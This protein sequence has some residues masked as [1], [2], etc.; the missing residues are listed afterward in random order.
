MIKTLAKS[1]RENKLASILSPI[2]MMGEVA[3]EV[4][5]P[6]L[7][8]L[9]IDNG[10]SEENLPYVWKIGFWMLVSLLLS[11]GCGVLSAAMAAKASVGLATNLRTDM[12]YHIQGFSFEN[13]DKFS[14]A[15]LITRL[16]TDVTNIQN[17]YQMIIRMLVRAPLMV[18]FSL[19]MAFTIDF[20]LP[21]VFVVTVPVLSFALYYLITHAHGFFMRMFKIYDRMNQVVQENLIGIRTVKAY[22]REKEEIKKFEEQS[23]EIRNITIA[24]EKLMILNAPIMFG[25]VYFCT[26]TLCYFGANMIVRGQLGTGELMSLIT[27]TMQILLSLMMV[28]MVL[29]TCVMARASGERIVEVLNEE[30]TLTN[31][32]DPDYEVKDGSIVFE[33]VSFAYDGRL[34]NT[35]LEHVSLSIPSGSVVGII[36]GTGSSKTTMVS[37]ISRLYDVTAGRVLVGGKDVRDYDIEA[38]RNAVSVVLQKNELF[39]GTIKENLRW[40][41]KD[42]TDEEII[43]ACKLAQADEFIEKMADT[44]DTYIEQGGRNVS[45]G[46]KQRLCIARALLKHPKILILDDSTSAVDTATDQK[47][48]RGFASYI[49]ETTKIIIAQRISS[50]QQ[51]DMIVILDDGKINGI[52]DHETL[53]RENEIYRD[54]YEAQNKEVSEA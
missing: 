2:F 21:W 26:L 25:A 18:V 44:Y 27:Y 42:A 16:T 50:V 9:M 30:S 37:L 23:S 54:I 35:V 4:V 19:V 5:V 13:I 29:I 43:E 51:A 8:A 38:L 32:E 40:G 3:G 6:Y 24:A 7:M 49:P 48:R 14:T 47:I 41:K 31:K 33:D 52:G 12:Y 28:S 15:S 39:S 17:A 45:G 46:Q 20:K 36:G 11:M 22:V 10:F 53:L 1:V 34:D